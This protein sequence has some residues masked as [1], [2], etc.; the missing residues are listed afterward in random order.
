[1]KI[2][3]VKENNLQKNEKLN[4]CE[5]KGFFSVIRELLETIFLVDAPFS[6]K[7]LATFSAFYSVMFGFVS[8]FAEI[9]YKNLI[10]GLGL[11]SY[12]IFFLLILSIV[13]KYIENSKNKLKGDK[14]E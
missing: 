1:V 3:N 2:L 7:V 6:I 4:E 13:I 10:L 12:S 8:L 9:K 14:N 5:N 11:L